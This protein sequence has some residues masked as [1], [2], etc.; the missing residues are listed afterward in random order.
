[1]AG[2][3]TGNPNALASALVKIGYGL[4]ARGEQAAEEAAEDQKGKKKTKKATI[5]AL[6]GIGALGIFDRK[7]AV[8]MV[9]SSAAGVGLGTAGSGSIRK[10]NLKSA[11][12]WDLWNPWATFYE[13]NSTHP[14]VAHRLEYLGDQAAVMGQEPFVVFDRRKPESYWDDF[15]ADL[16]VLLLSFL[17]LLLG[18]AAAAG[19]GHLTRVPCASAACVGPVRR[20]L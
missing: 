15:A 11:M 5:P 9:A 19:P 13:L 3:V 16:L 7:S 17:L 20:A 8:A 10:E 6:D 12:Q 2:R 18:L 14:L 1:F 4:A